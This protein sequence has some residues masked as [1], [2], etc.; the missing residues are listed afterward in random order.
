[1][2]SSG[3]TTRKEV[4]MDKEIFGQK[5]WEWIM[6]IILVIIANAVIDHALDK[7]KARVEKHGY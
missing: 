7:E 3:T 2:T 1:M 4:T 5:V 6:L